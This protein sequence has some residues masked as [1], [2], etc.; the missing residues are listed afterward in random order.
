M[1][2]LPNLFNKRNKK[3]KIPHT[4]VLIDRTTKWG[5]P[6]PLKTDTEE[7][8][9]EDIFQY[10]KWIELNPK[11]QAQMKKELRGK[12]LVCWCFPKLCH[13]HIILEIAN[14]E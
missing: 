4:A 1:K 6:F 9:E 5:N 3:I 11:L 12:D 14:N 13:G 8:R 2:E 7:E 10:V